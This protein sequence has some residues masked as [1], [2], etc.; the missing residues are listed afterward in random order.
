MQHPAPLRG[1]SFDE[2]I[3]MVMMTGKL[4]AKDLEFEETLNFRSAKLPCLS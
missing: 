4:S 2:K 1:L 3:M